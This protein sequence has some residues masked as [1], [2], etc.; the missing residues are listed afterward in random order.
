M[1]LMLNDNQS[2]PARS[3][4]VLCW[5][6]FHSFLPISG[7]ITGVYTTNSAESVRHVLESSRANIVVVDDAKQMEKVH[8][9]KN[10][11]PHL[12]AVIQTTAPYAPYVR[13]EDG[14]YRV[15]HSFLKA[16]A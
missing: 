5:L 13:K 4:V 12:K 16:T 2:Y 11:L 3:S 6:L 14:Y 15:C 7:I 10:Q 9:I 8:S 1:M